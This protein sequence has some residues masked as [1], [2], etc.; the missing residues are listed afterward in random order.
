[1]LLQAGGDWGLQLLPLQ[2]GYGLLQQEQQEQ[3]KHLL[4]A[5]YGLQLLQLKLQLQA[6]CC[7]WLLQLQ[8]LQAPLPVLPV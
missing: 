3:Q 6:I 7:Y 4:Q 2:A 1:M 5:G 8:Q